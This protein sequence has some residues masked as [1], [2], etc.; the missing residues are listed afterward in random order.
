M[1][2]EDIR[3]QTLLWVEQFVIGLSLCPF[4]SAPMRAGLVHVRVSDATSPNS[5]AAD[6]TE[7]VTALL[8]LSR[9]ERETTLLVHPLV[10]Q[11]FE[12]YL[13]FLDEL[14]PLWEDAMLDGVLQVASFHPQYCFADAP[15]DDPANATN[16]SPFPMLHLLREDSV[17][18]VL[19]QHP[20]PEGIPERNVKLLRRMGPEG[21]QQILG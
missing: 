1:T 6:L 8:N 17:A 14:A 16:R 21:I 9:A 11:D 15:H 4:A 7:E 10:L 13:D 3:Q 18:E 19:E 2:K 12:E 5:L 20:D